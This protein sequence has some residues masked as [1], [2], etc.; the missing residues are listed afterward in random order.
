MSDKYHF[1]YNVDFN[2]K[3][4]VNQIIKLMIFTNNYFKYNKEYILD[5]YNIEDYDEFRTY[6]KKNYK[7]KLIFNC[8]KSE[9]LFINFINLDYNYFC[10]K[11]S[12]KETQTIMNFFITGK[13]FYFNKCNEVNSFIK[14][15][16]HIPKCNCKIKVKT[17]ANLTINTLI[18]ILK[19]FAS[20]Y[21]ENLNTNDYLT[22]NTNTTNNTNNSK[23]F[24][25][26][27]VVKIPKNEINKELVSCLS[28][29]ENLENKLGIDCDINKH[30]VINSLT[31]NDIKPNTTNKGDKEIIREVRDENKS[32]GFTFGITNITNNTN[33]TKSS[34]KNKKFY[35][36]NQKDSSDSTLYKNSN[37]E[38]KEL[39]SSSENIF[40][41]LDAYDIAGKNGIGE[42]FKINNFKNNND[43]DNFKKFYKFQVST[44]ENKNNDNTTFLSKNNKQ[45]DSDIIDL[46]SRSSKNILKNKSNL[47]TNIF[48]QN[49]QIKE[50]KEIK[51]NK[52]NKEISLKNDV[53]ILN[54]K[55]KRNIIVEEEN[56]Q[57]NHSNNNFETP[58]INYSIQSENSEQS[59]KS[60]DN[61]NISDSVI[62]MCN[63]ELIEEN[64]SKEN[65]NEENSN[66]ENSN[67]ENS[68]EE[69]SNEEN[70]N[71]EI[72]ID[73]NMTITEFLNTETDT[74]NIKGLDIVEFDNDTSTDTVLSQ[75][76]NLD[77]IKSI[78]LIIQ[79][80]DINN[81]VLVDNPNTISQLAVEIKKNIKINYSEDIARKFDILFQKAMMTKIISDTED[82]RDYYNLQKDMSNIKNTLSK[83][84]SNK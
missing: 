9:K 65:S 44:E 75:K 60:I 11:Y 4:L 20:S 36:K 48:K 10:N 71:E 52:E 7:S 8:S 64:S 3:D 40:N 61:K 72:V 30:Y 22:N 80:L 39:S 74:N 25:N 41:N 50:I 79:Y 34:G 67:E 70:S 81:N 42:T 14:D 49:K 58:N 26:K 38:K 24:T 83:M 54:N 43:N 12:G 69:N 56:L 46:D 76:E 51:E 13:L 21:N 17:I 32:L 33:N 78:D 23:N 18:F 82:M 66:E 62:K 29:L 1:L 73:K 5:K 77:I 68:N 53:Q 55:I 31:E 6:F 2:S 28:K 19:E 47:D 37:F 15:K 57:N 16:N 63:S 45:L 35:F 84:I 59:K 27:N